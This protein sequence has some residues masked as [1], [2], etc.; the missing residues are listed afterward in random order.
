VDIDELSLADE[1]IEVTATVVNGDVSD[2]VATLTPL[3]EGEG[4]SHHEFSRTDGGFSL[5]L[6]GRHSGGYRIEVGA[7]QSGP[8]V[9]PAV[10]DVFVVAG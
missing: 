6:S 8:G 4:P 5:D 1:P 7:P 2:L 10:H 9:P 3:D